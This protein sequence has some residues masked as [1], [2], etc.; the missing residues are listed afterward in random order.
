MKENK[1]YFFKARPIINQDGTILSKKRWSQEKIE[2]VKKVIG[3]VIFQC[4]YMLN[5]LDDS[6]GLI[7]SSWILKSFD[8]TRSFITE[9]PKWAKQ[10][11]MGVDFAFSD[12]LTA[13]K[14]AFIIMATTEILN[15]QTKQN[16]LKYVILDIISRQGMS[17]LEQFELMKQLHSVYRFDMIGIE[18]NS[19]KAISKSISSFNLPI[20][21]YWTGSSDEK[22]EN[23]IIKDYETIGK[24]N[25]IIRIGNQL[26]QNKVIIPYDENAKK[27]SDELYNELITFAQED[28]K[29]VEIGIHS[30]K[31]MALGFA[32][33]TI[34]RINRGFLI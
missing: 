23:G 12:R 29:V 4:E 31:G 6:T 16:E 9:R 8:K 13:D 24:R 18:E 5:P 32:L 15:E 10:M 19:I 3:S 27:M 30:D 20:K 7:R 21:R 17:G 25:L 28:G 1:S 33:E 14:S 26:E 11:V 2:N 34:D 22:T